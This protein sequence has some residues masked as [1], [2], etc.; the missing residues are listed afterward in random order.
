MENA[1]QLLLSSQIKTK[2]YTKLVDMFYGT[3][4]S[5]NVFRGGLLRLGMS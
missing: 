3:F 1:N 2:A 5:R 4:Y